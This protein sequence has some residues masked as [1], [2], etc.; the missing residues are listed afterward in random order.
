[1]FKRT[2]KF[3]APAILAAA[4]SACGGGGSSSSTSDNTGST[5]G[6]TTPTTPATPAVQPATAQASSTCTTPTYAALSA[7]DWVMS[8]RGASGAYTATRGAVCQNST[9]DQAASVVA[10]SVGQGTPMTLAAVQA[11]YNPTYGGQIIDVEYDQH[12]TSAYDCAGAANFKAHSLYAQGRL[13]DVGAYSAQNPDSTWTC[14]LVAGAKAGTGDLGQ[15]P[16]NEV[17][18]YYHP[19][20]NGNYVDR[21]PSLTPYIDINWSSDVVAATCASGGACAIGQIDAIDGYIGYP[22]DPMPVIPSSVAETITFAGPGALVENQAE[23]IDS[24]MV[25][26]NSTMRLNL[27][28]GC[29]LQTCVMTIDY[30]YQSTAKRLT[31]TYTDTALVSQVIT[32]R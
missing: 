8:Q 21:K 26:Q 14:V 18:V 15:I 24:S 12:G 32:N 7:G 11:Q 13:T 31:I 5:G 28:R 23:V 16:V 19:V 1:M 20:I 9:L 27:E 2:M 17:S 29:D 30:T 6:T 22:T 3:L 25:R 4:L 10:A